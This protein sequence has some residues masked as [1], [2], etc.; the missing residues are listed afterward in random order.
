MTTANNWILKAP[1]AFLTYITKVW[2][3]MLYPMLLLYYITRPDNSFFPTSPRKFGL[4]RLLYFTRAVKLSPR[5]SRI[6]DNSWLS[7]GK[8]VLCGD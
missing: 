6:A 3:E 2:V 7:E 5:Q 4:N 1:A 8:G